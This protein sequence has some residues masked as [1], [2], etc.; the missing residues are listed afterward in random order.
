MSSSTEF[1]KVSSNDTFDVLKCVACNHIAISFFT[2]LA[3]I[4]Y[5][6]RTCKKCSGEYVYPL[7]KN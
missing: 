3:T 6:C 1:V 4:R 2:S 7:Q 5:R